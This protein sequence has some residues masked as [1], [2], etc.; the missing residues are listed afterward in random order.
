MEFF[1]N[2]KRMCCIDLQNKSM[3]FNRN[4]KMHSVTLIHCGRN[5]HF[6]RSYIHLDILFDKQW[7]NEFNPS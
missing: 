6:I 7:N 4:F 1:T 3:E 5:L 2:K